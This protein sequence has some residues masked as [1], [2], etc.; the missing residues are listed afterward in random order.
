MAAIASNG[1]GGG[2]WA[3]GA[4]WTGGVAPVSGDTAT[5]A[6]NDTI[7]VVTSTTATVGNTAALGNAVTIAGGGTLTINGTLVCQGSVTSSG[8]GTTDATLLV[9]GGG[10]LQFDTSAI[11][12]SPHAAINPGANRFVLNLA[13]TS[14]TNLATVK[15]ATAAPT[16]KI[17][18][19]ARDFALLSDYADIKDA[20]DGSGIAADYTG[21]TTKAT[22]VNH[23]IFTNTGQWRLNC[24]AAVDMQ[25]KNSSF[26]SSRDLYNL[27]PRMTASTTGLRVFQNLVL[28][29]RFLADQSIANF[30]VTG[31]LMQDRVQV[32]G[33]TT[34]GAALAVSG[35]LLTNNDTKVMSANGTHTIADNY[36]Y[37]TVATNPHG[38]EVTTAQTGAQTVTLDGNVY[39]HSGTDGTGN[40]FVPN[41]S[42]FSASATFNILRNI[43]LPNA[44]GKSS[45]DVATMYGNQTNTA[46][47]IEHNTVC[48]AG[49]G[50]DTQAL[51]QINE[52]NVGINSR[53]YPANLVSFKSN[54]AWSG[55]AGQGSKARMQAVRG[56][57][58]T[59]TS[60][61]SNSST[62][63]NDTGKSWTTNQWQTSFL[64]KIVAGTG[65]NQVRAIASNTATQVTVSSA[66][67]T[68]P[69]ATSQY[70]I[71][72]LDVLTPAKADY[73]GSY[74]IASGTLYNETA[75]VVSYSGKGYDNQYM[76]AGN[77]PGVHDVDDVNPL[78][79]DTSRK[80]ATWDTS[81]GGP[82]TAA[83]ALAEIAKMNDRVGYNS[84]YSIAALVSY[85]KGGYVPYNFSFLAAH[86]GTWIGAVNGPVGIGQ[87]TETDVA[88][89]VTGRKSR[90]IGQPAEVGQ[91]QPVAKRKAK[92]VAQAMETDTAQ[93]V[94]GA[95]SAAIGMVTETDVA[96]PVRGRKMKNVRLMRVSSVVGL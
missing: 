80:L 6:A 34:A 89:P 75:S 32:G 28:D 56:A 40:F 21:G 20:D 37:A 85:V 65:I 26:V 74:Q 24:G 27:V 38:I 9:N 33:T 51:A 76:T 16:W 31:S 3:S 15:A 96:Q 83:H 79:A 42:S 81:L 57:Q 39:E 90:T 10:T 12:G 69:D 23:T 54:L 93:A 25:W 68:T 5:I 70:E 78:F 44:G 18:S 53:V 73:N 49:T 86:D 35:N 72:A 4:S 92:A 62:T 82:G 61:G 1:T 60:T 22:S 36:F 67:T 45:G 84:A 8:A 58:V 64:I 52:Q 46:W 48:V 63:L 30:D 91:S 19:N 59:G 41:I 43:S 29:K 47:T 13:G 55:S 71:Y 94:T 2:N 50:G 14:P 88:Q 66:W 11:S 87:A 17:T 7:T 95:R 77:L